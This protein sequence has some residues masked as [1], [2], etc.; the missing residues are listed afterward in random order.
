MTKNNTPYKP[1]D[2]VR[3]LGKPGVYTIH[4][5]YRLDIWR[6]Y[7]LCEAPWVFVEE[8]LLRRIEDD[9]RARD[10]MLAR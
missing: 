9:T 1:G 8:R 2:K 7:S 6:V 10:A 5:G 4:A 3:V